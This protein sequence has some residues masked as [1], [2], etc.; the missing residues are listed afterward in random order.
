M[1]KGA[2][3]TRLTTAWGMLALKTLRGAARR[4]GRWPALPGQLAWQFSRRNTGFWRR[5]YA[6][7]SDRQAFREWL[8][9]IHDPAI[10]T[11][12]FEDD[13]PLALHDGVG[14][15][16]ARLVYLYSDP[17]AWDRLAPDLPD[18]A[19]VEAFFDARSVL[20]RVIRTEC[21]AEDLAAVMQDVGRPDM[22]AARLEA[23]GRTN[24]SKR[25]AFETYHDAASIALIAERD[26]MIVDRFGYAPPQFAVPEPA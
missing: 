10:Q 7:A 19:S 14:L 17:V 5:V 15:Y 26:A 25:D 1:G 2:I 22:T 4:P 21:I 12:V 23:E 3:E 13:R 18:R 11:V 20:Q 16:T 9:A 24:T 6:D 8:H